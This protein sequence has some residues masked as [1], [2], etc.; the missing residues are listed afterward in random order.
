MSEMLSPAVYFRCSENS[1]ENPWNGLA[2]NPEMN[3]STMNLAR[4]S[5]RA[6]WRMT[7]GFRC[8]SAVLATGQS[9]LSSSRAGPSGDDVRDRDLEARQQGGRV[10][11]ARREHALLIAALGVPQ[12]G[13]PLLGYVND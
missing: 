1:T 8:F 12:D 2:C 4:R 5:S 6:T 7:S 9:S 10:D 3:P 11:V 13:D